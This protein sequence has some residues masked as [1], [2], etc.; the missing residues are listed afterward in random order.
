M[1]EAVQLAVA[2]SLGGAGSFEGAD[3]L[4]VCRDQG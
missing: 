1:S 2:Q 3:L 4:S